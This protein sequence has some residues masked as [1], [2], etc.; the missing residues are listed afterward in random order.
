M[1]LDLFSPVFD[2]SH[3]DGVGRARQRNIEPRL[4]GQTCRAGAV[5]PIVEFTNLA[6]G[7]SLAEL[8]RAPWFDVGS[9]RTLLDALTGTHHQW[10][11]AD[12]R[13]GMLKD[14]GLAAE[15]KLRSFKIDAHKA[16]LGAS[17]GNAAPLLVAAMG[18]L[19]GNVIDHSQAEES[20]VAIFSARAGLFEFVVA[21]RGIGVLRSLRQCPNYRTVADEGAALAAMVETGVSRHGP[22]GGHG[23][24]FRP[25]FERLADMT[26]QLRF[27]S[28]N[29][30]LSLDGQFGDRIGRQLSQK[31]A[32]SG[33][34]AAVLC[35]GP[36]QP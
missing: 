12:G 25:I 7:E 30:A 3:V 20:G 33:F 31:P 14:Q 23:N 34:F 16:A 27:R 22:N 32:L 13:C 2:Y 29:Y 24:G 10:L 8:R 26:G 9:R 17:F 19:I 11:Q 35:R 36:G 21:D 5:G 4:D 15:D 1:P 18:E 28:G 6:T